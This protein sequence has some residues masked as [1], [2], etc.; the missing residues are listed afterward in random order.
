[1]L[2]K[3]LIKYKIKPSNNVETKDKVAITGKLSIKRSVS[4]AEL[5]KFGY[6]PTT[7][8]NKETLFLITDN[9]NSSS[10]KNKQ[11]DKFG[12]V[13]ITEGDFRRKYMN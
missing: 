3:T 12:I 8:V 9:P 6:E 13:K 10:S 5:R 11:A 7:S 2:R 4:E 1:M